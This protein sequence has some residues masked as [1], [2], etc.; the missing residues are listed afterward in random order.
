MMPSINTINMLWF[1][2]VGWVPSM[3][4]KTS[5]TMLSVTA[6][7]SE[8]PLLLIWLGELA[9]ERAGI[10]FKPHRIHGG[11]GGGEAQAE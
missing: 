2:P 7:Q 4:G 5:P 11:E 1:S 8:M 10:Q 3:K 9:F 6:K